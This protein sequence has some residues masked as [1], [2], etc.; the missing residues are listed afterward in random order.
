LLVAIT[1]II[2]PHLSKPP[3]ERSRRSREREPRAGISPYQLGRHLSLGHLVE[4]LAVQRNDVIG[5]DLFS[6]AKVSR[7][8]SG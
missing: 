5:V 3:G 4:G 1:G 2:F 8:Y 7:R 6:A